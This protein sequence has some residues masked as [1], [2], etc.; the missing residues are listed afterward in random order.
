MEGGTNARRRRL[1]ERGADRL[2]FITGQAQTLPSDP[3]PGKKKSKKKESKSFVLMAVAKS[4]IRSMLL[5]RPDLIS[6][7]VM[8]IVPF[9]S[10]ELYACVD[11]LAWARLSVRIAADVLNRSAIHY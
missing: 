11:Y 1:V 8:I 10:R 7:V 4:V 5:S 9:C 6:L 2:A 3:L